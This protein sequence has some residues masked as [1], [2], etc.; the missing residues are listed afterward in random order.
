MKAGECVFSGSLQAMNA[1]NP[2]TILEEFF[3]IPSFTH[4]NDF[5][6]DQVI[7]L[8]LKLFFDINLTHSFF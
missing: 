4:W 3:M 8:Y 7:F 1:V 2:L 6:L 5:S